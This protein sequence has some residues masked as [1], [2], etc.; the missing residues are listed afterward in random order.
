MRWTGTRSQSPQALLTRVRRLHFTLMAKEGYCRVWTEQCNDVICPIH[1]KHHWG[2]C[3]GENLE[4]TGGDRRGHSKMLFG[5]LHVFPEVISSDSPIL[6]LLDDQ[7]FSKWEYDQTKARSSQQTVGMWTCRK[8]C[9]THAPDSFLNLLLVTFL[10]HFQ[11]CTFSY[12][13]LQTCNEKKKKKTWVT[14]IT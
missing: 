11:L 13:K 4:G 9:F 3:L 8:I 14:W 7:A 2:C 5:K 12:S 6:G 1:A 10:P